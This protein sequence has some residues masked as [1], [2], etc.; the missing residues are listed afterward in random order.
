MSCE[1]WSSVAEFELSSQSSPPKP[2]VHRH[3]Y[4]APCTTWAHTPPFW[5]GVLAQ[6]PERDAG[7]GGLTG[8]ML[9]GAGAGAILGAMLGAMF[10]HTVIFD[11]QPQSGH[12]TIQ[13]IQPVFGSSHGVWP[14]WSM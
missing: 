13:V 1:T 2:F 4:S 5:H 8:A 3:V 6:P 12:C 7:G 9:Q 11:T 14:G 10:G